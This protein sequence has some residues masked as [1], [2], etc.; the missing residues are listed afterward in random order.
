MLRFRLLLERDDDV[1][2]WDRRSC[3]MRIM[4]DSIEGDDEEDE[5][6]G[7]AGKVALNEEHF[8][9]IMKRRKTKKEEGILSRVIINNFI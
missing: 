2:F 4:S 1:N 6:G 9:K 5:G 3:S 8:R 7:E